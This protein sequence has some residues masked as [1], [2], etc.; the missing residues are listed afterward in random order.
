MP[1]ML[2][3]LK[4]I[5][6]LSIKLI[7]VEAKGN[8]PNYGIYSWIQRLNLQCYFL[9]GGGGEIFGNLGVLG[10]IGAVTTRAI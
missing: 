3:V 8:L 1:G 2:L 6:G 4:A 7:P 9:G 5:L 10:V